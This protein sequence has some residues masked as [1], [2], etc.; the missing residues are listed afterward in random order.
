LDAQLAP[1]LQLAESVEGH[2]TAKEARM[3]GLLAALPT[4]AGEI[5]EI[6]S[7]KGK[8]AII[9][10]RAAQLADRARVVAVD[11]LTSPCITDPDLK[12]QRSGW[13][14][15]QNNLR[16][17]GVHEL[18]E[19]HQKFSHELA[20]VWN[21]QRQLR[22][23]WIDGDHTHRGAKLDFDKFVPFVRDGGIVAFHDVLHNFDGPLRVFV[24]DLLRSPRF[25]AAGVCGSIGWAQLRA[26]TAAQEKN[27][28]HLA[29]ALARLIPLATN[30]ELRGLTKLRFKLA[31]SRV[32][33]GA[34][35]AAEFVRQTAPAQP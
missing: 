32:P 1:I 22:L 14:D 21:P 4:A 20:A 10:A 35:S 29:R 15:F 18:V 28:A 26:P 5:L 16:R 30:T 17:G 27:K 31:R 13:E 33:R 6:G 19:F 23:L 7:F 2:L 8:S 12:G 25:G 3:L 34:I 9:L 24:E 11:P